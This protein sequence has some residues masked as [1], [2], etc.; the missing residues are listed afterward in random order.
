MLPRL[1]PSILALF[2]VAF[3]FDTIDLCRRDMS[4]VRENTEAY[5]DR[6]LLKLPLPWLSSYDWLRAAQLAPGAQAAA[7]SACRRCASDASLCTRRWR[8][9]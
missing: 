8:P 2:I 5:F 3:W 6:L 1:A 4:S 9:P 7:S